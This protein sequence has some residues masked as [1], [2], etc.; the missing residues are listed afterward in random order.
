MKTL[1]KPNVARQLS[2]SIQLD[3]NTPRGKRFSR[4]MLLRVVAK[5]CFF[6][7]IDIVIQTSGMKPKACA[8]RCVN[9]SGMKFEM[10]PTLDND[11]CMLETFKSQDFLGL[12]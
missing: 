1:R 2:S 10:H 11:L 4:R 6:G 5:T 3:S 12:G 7:I 8:L 9:F